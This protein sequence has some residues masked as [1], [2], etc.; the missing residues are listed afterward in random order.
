M[1]TRKPDWRRFEI[2]LSG[3][4]FEPRYNIAP[5]QDIWVLHRDPSRDTPARMRWGLVPGWADDPAIGYR[6]INARSETAADKPAFRSAMKYRRCAVPADGFY[7][8]KHTGDHKQPHL[9]QSADEAIFYM[10]GLHE[11]WQDPAGNELFTATIL[12]C[13]PNAMMQKLHDR[14]PVILPPDRLDDWLNPD[15]QDASAAAKMLEPYPAQLM[16]HRPVSTRV[17]AVKHD[18]P[19]LLEPPSG[20]QQ[21]LF[22]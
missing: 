16:M 10:A 20:M 11:H 14:M 5:G 17:N 12:T 15:R 2:D 8:W 13:Q 9:I 4:D 3:V 1:L 19:E 21:G 18:G 22:G 6:M 7:E